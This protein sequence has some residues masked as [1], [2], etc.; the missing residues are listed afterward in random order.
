MLLPAGL[1]RLE[2]TDARQARQSETLDRD[3]HL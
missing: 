1:L 2:E 3:R